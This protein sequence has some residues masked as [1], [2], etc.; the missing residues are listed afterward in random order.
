M[1]IPKKFMYNLYI[2]ILLVDILH[3]L[4]DSLSGFALNTHIQ[5]VISGLMA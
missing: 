4:G 1:V 3:K 2:V 5:R